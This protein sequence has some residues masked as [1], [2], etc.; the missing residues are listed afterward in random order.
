MLLLLCVDI[1]RIKNHKRSISD[2]IDDPRV[3][4]GCDQVR[5]HYMPETQVNRHDNQIFDSAALT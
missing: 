4:E 3:P 2:A 5:Y 1:S